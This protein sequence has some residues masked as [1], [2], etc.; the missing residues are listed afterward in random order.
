LSE[1]KN[2]IQQH[3]QNLKSR[4]NRFRATQKCRLSELTKNANSSKN[5]LK[6][7]CD[8]AERI[9]KLAEL[10][11][12]ME[13]EQEKVAPFYVSSVEGE[14]EK[15]AEAMVQ[16]QKEEGGEATGKRDDGVEVT[17]LNSSA[18]SG[19]SGKP[20]GKWNHLDNF[21]K[22]YNKVLLDALSIEKAEETLRKENSD[23]QEI[24]QQYF[25]GISVNDEVLKK[26]N[27][28]FVTNFKVNLNKPLPVR[29]E[30]ES[31]ANM[32]FVEANAVI[33]NQSKFN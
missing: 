28:L 20:V 8:L 6:D 23:L 5:I 31:T 21:W 12:K 27:P 4:M 25:D 14:I 13:T 2:G 15:Q 17:P 33:A 11:R 3:F 26:D 7:K 19:E 22:K 29:R 1:E 16:K 9:L 30:G 10:G 24:L 18:W 32:T